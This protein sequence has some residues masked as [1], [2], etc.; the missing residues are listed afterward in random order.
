MMGD[1]PRTRAEQA[2]TGHE[3]RKLAFHC[4]TSIYED[5]VKSQWPNPKSQT[6]G[7]GF[8]FWVLGFSEPVLHAELHDPHVARVRGDTSEGAGAQDQARIAPVEVVE[9]VERLD[10][11]LERLR[12]PEGNL[13]GKRGVNR[14]VARAADAVPLVA[15]E[16][17]EH[18]LRERSAVEIGVEPLTINVVAH[19]IDALF[20]EALAVERAVAA[21]GDVQP[22]ARARI[23]NPRQPPARG[24]GVDDGVAEL[25]G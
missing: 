4:A 16:R 17:A 7:L 24:Q 6:D 20:L 11:Q 19:L 14:P 3:H 18:R 23:E 1:Q 21:G 12:G 22:A 13:L 8:G 10:A 2:D 5:Y 9:Q 25:R 15:A